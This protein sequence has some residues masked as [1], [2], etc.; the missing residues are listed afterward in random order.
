MGKTFLFLGEQVHYT[1]KGKGKAIVLIHGFLGSHQVWD[2]YSETILKNHQLICIDLPGH[3]KSPAIAFVHQMELLAELL[4]ALRKHLKLKKW[5]LVGHSLGGYVALAYAEL[6][7]NAIRKLILINSSANADGEERKKSRDKFVRLLKKE[8]VRA[9][10]L[11]VPS[12]FEGTATLGRGSRIKA[13]LK[14]AKRASLKGI[15]AS[16]EGMKLR[17]QRE[18]IL[19]FAPYPFLLIGS[20]NDSIVPLKNMEHQSKLN[21]NGEFVCLENASH[22]SILEYPGKLSK[23]IH[24]FI[25]EP[26][27]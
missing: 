8:Q 24:Q 11:L 3:G 9:I 15:I 27:S 10:E 22:M 19:K 12:F 16:V 4:E 1:I 21:S 23:I 25:N 7:P 26:N 5:S 20:K 17:K 14:Q 2:A 18:I 6:F 13:Y